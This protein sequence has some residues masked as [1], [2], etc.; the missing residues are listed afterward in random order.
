MPRP[1]SPP[2]RRPAVR[3][4]VEP[5]EARETPAVFTVT[6]VNSTGANSLEWAIQ[7]T[8]SS[9]GADEIVFLPG[10]F[11]SPKT[12]NLTQSLPEINPLGSTPGD[13][14]ITGPGANLLT[15]TRDPNAGGTFAMFRVTDG[16]VSISG[17]TIAG[18]AGNSNDYSGGIRQRSGTLTLDNMVFANNKGVNGGAVFA[19]Q[20]GV[21][22]RNSTFTGNEA[23]GEGGALWARNGL[24]VSNT[25]FNGNTAG[26]VG[27]AV[28]VDVGLQ[29][30]DTIFADNEAG[31]LGGAVYVN[32]GGGLRA[33]NTTVT[34]NTAGDTGGGVYVRDGL[35]QTRDTIV[36]GNHAAVQG[37][38]I[39][40]GAGTLDIQD[41]TISANTAGTG[42][43]G[44][45]VRGD[46]GVVT[47][48]RTSTISGNVVVGSGNQTGYG[49]GLY[50]RHADAGLRIEGCTIS[51]N[52]ATGGGGGLFFRQVGTYPGAPTDPPSAVR[53][54]TVIGNT[55]G[56][57]G[58][59][60]DVAA[61]DAPLHIENCTVTGNTSTDTTEQGHGGGGIAHASFVGTL[62]IYNSVV[63][64]NTHP[65]APDLVGRYNP[66]EVRSSAIGSSLGWTPTAASGNNLPFN[67]DLELGP[68]ADNGGPTLTR[69][70]AYGSPL[71]D[72]GSN[73]LV[74]PGVTTDQRGDGFARTAGLSTDIGAVELQ[75][76]YTFINQAADQ[77]DPTATG[78]IIFTV[79]FSAP[80]AGFT[81]SDVD[82]TG[83]TVGGSLAATVTGSGTDYTITV[84]GMTATGDVVVSVP[85]GAAADALGIPNEASTSTD[86]VVR[87]D[88]DGPTAAIDLAPGQADPT[89]ED[90]V[91]FA[92]VF[93]EPVTGFDAADVS[94][95]GSTV[96]GSLAATITGSG[97][98]YT[99]SVSGMTGT[100]VVVI[101]VPAGAAQDAAGNP[102]RVASPIDNSITFDEFVPHVTINQAAGQRDPTNGAI[103]FD[104]EFSEPVFGFDPSD[105]DFTRSTVGGVLS[106]AIS[107]SGPAYVVTLTG[108]TGA[109]TVVASIPAGVVT[110]ATPL[111]NLASTST[112]NVVE[113]D[114][115][116]PT[117]TVNQSSGQADPT[118]ASPISFS[119]EFSKPVT[120]FDSADVSLAGS[121]IGG[122]LVADVTG[123][124]AS[125]TVTVTGMFGGG[126]VVASIPAGIAADAVG[127]ANLASTSTDNS[128]YFNNIGTLQFDSVVQTGTE[129]GG[130]ATVTVSRVNG[131]DGQVSIDVVTSDGLA[132]AGLDYTA[133]TE[134]LNWADGEGGSKSFVVHILQDDV[135]EGWEDVVLT[136]TNP[137]GN[138]ALGLATSRVVILPSD[139]HGPGTFFD[140]DGDRVTLKL[141]GPGHLA[142]YLYDP[143]GDGR[144]P[145]DWLQ[146]TDTNP[147]KSSVALSVRKSRATTD[148][149]R[150]G[151]GVVTG[152]GLRSLSANKANLVGGGLGVAPSGIALDGYLGSLRIGDVRNGADI[153]A[154]ALPRR[155]TAIVAGA[156][157]DG[158][159]ISVAG[160]LRSLTATSIGAGSVT[161]PSIGTMTVRGDLAADVTVTGAGVAA[162]RPAL[163][164]LRVRGAIIGSDIDVGGNVTSV[165]AARFL[166]SR[167][168]A[169]Y[170]G[171]DDGSGTFSSPATTI[172]SFRVTG[173]TDAFANSTVI[174]GALQSV[175]LKSVLGENNHDP[176]GFIANDSINSLKVTSTGFVYDRFFPLTQGFDDFEIRVL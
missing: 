138:P 32:A 42:G 59:G 87:F 166:D 51:G 85:A 104:V 115:I 94:F 11:T 130:S 96:G 175:V 33:Q 141:A 118:N 144:G 48:V 93:S 146:L 147:L 80:V 84:T 125:Y 171:P 173:A 76:V 47:D 156:I 163:G 18:G 161:A 74:D 148:G 106:A 70:P 69:H 58:G 120:G 113:F 137:V 107:G 2:V 72:A 108:M 172:R 116:A 34:G 21:D 153:I 105:I 37:G 52:S 98:T 162:G 111:P 114:G 140:A 43:G 75:P 168:L 143:D 139:P 13:V 142:Y 167:L 39:Y 112:D 31:E 60:I 152:P 150:V 29:T 36:T 3:L 169:G 14:T 124:G 81:A 35:L 123:T 135:N 45:Y 165:S 5:L 128:V 174:A 92:V 103:E 24:L 89:S 61:L 9:P 49:A 54:C 65:T 46:L 157:G 99:V 78:P 155:K 64:G 16:N 122:T 97:D 7:G 151:L 22:V 88:V 82:F 30:E 4:R 132:R 10:L 154:G 91:R 56:G 1:I 63:S 23:T 149:G 129:D 67:L 17:L 170:D 41:T 90:P 131:A 119:V 109:G 62:Q 19:Q 176:F 20:A 102:S 44:I 117:V 127:N 126:T 134:T 6:N 110:D 77:P 27:G 28:S 101:S 121:T 57:R 164:S 136:L 159:A 79:A 40:L 8:N 133:A 50:F 158:T 15:I 100:G 145:I 95:A 38:G 53:N 66:I 68:V 12:I 83:S 73:A 25:T 55:A 86:N 26:S 160:P 71:V